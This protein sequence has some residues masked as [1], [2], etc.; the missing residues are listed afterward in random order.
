MAMKK[1]MGGMKGEVCMHC[2]GTNCH[3]MKWMFIVKAVI[4]LV[5]GYMLWIGKWSL[6][7]TIAYLLVLMGIKYLW[8]GF[9]CR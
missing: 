1:E 9:K 7:A 8:V 4:L 6:E 5:F 2:G 3:C